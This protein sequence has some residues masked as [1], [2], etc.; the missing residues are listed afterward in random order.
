MIVRS[1]VSL[2]GSVKKRNVRELIIDLNLDL[3]FHSKG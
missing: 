3:F 2:E 1:L